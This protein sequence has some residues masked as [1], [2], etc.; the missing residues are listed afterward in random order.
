MVGTHSDSLS[1]TFSALSDPTRR[2]ILT[3]LTHGQA[4]VTELAEPFL[5]E[6]S[7]PAI[8]K[9]LKVLENAG[10][11]TR[12]RDAQFRPCRLNGVPLRE[13]SDWVEQY[14]K[15]WEESLDRLGA[16]LATVTTTPPAATP[17]TTEG[18]DD[19]H[20]E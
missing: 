10:L 8:T 20:S 12:T 3:K 1:S 9:H 19:V 17:A 6:M 15:F 4:S 7:L 16:Y 5:G 14:R 11:I 13:A 18:D 2:A